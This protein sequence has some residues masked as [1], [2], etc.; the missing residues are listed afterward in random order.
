MSNCARVAAMKKV[1]GLKTDAP[2]APEG[3]KEIGFAED[4]FTRETMREY[5]SKETWQKLMQTI[6]NGAPLDPSIAGEVA[7]AMRHWAMDRGA[8]HYTHWFLPLTG[9]TAEKHDSFLELKDGKPIM[10]FSARNLIV[11]EPDASSFPSG[12]IRSTFEARADIDRVIDGH[13]VWLR[14][15]ANFIYTM[16]PLVSDASTV[17]RIGAALVELASAPAGPEQTGDFHE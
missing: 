1:A 7:H 16:P 3:I 8:T 17:A 12:G 10:A 11:G 13:G 15:F 2:C 14:P 4:V 9:S 5:L 6:D